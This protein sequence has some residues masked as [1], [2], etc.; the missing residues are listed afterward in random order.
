MKASEVLELIA[1][2]KIAFVDLKF[3]D[4]PGSW[5]HVTLPARELDAGSF[6]AGLPFDGSSLRGFRQIEESDMIL[7]PDPETAFVDPFSAHSTLSLVADVLDPALRP[8]SRDPR[9]VARRAEAF[10]QA[11]GI[12]DRAYFGPELEFFV[13]DDVRFDNQPH[14]SF[15]T[16][17]GEESEWSGSEAGSRP[18]YRIRAK[19]GYAPVPPLDALS[20]LRSEMVLHLESIGL[21]V[22]RHHH[23]VATAGQGEIGFGHDT[24]LRTADNVLAFKYVVKNTAIENGRTA[25]FM[26]KPLFGDNGSGMHTHQ[27]L[28]KGDRPLFFDEAGYGRVSELALYYIGGILRHAPALVGLC[29]ASTNSFRRLVPGYEAPT[30]LVFAQGNRSAAVRIPISA[31]TAKTSRIEFRTPDSTGNPYLAFAAM[32]MAGLDGIRHRIDPRKLGM[33]PLDKNIYH[34]SD[35]ER[36]KIRSVPATLPEAL[37]EL[38]KDHAFLLEGDV[39]SRD[40][41]EAWIAYKLEHEVHPVALRPTPYEFH[42]YYDI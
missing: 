16:V 19:E 15:F 21:R 38:E 33:G 40:L 29:N 34:L 20:D 36:R 6:K 17:D 27:S 24:L 1:K 26:P 5:H 25:T 37:A 14:T 39:F 30:D 18:G 31:V 7:M 41:I 12:A 35:R 23:E 3:T 2:D 10:L 13:F 22:E 28:W 8:Y 42:L 11:S 32:L 4:L 9:G